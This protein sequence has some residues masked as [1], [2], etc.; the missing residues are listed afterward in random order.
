MHYTSYRQP[1]KTHGLQIVIILIGYLVQMHTALL[2]QIQALLFKALILPVV[3]S[4]LNGVLSVVILN[5]HILHQQSKKVVEHILTLLA[6]VFMPMLIS[7]GAIILRVNS[8][9]VALEW[10]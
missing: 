2:L 5:H 10:V 4:F 7:T 9:V 8:M 3:L 6:L 1:R